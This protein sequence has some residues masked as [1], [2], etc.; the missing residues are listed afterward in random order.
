MAWH[1]R[2]MTGAA[3]AASHPT[4]GAGRPSAFV[5]LALEPVLPQWFSGEGTS[6][7]P[8]KRLMLAIL[9]DAIELLM[10]DPARQ[11]ARRALCQRKAAHWIYSNDR[12]WF[13]SFVNVCETL[14]YDPKRIRTGIA[15]SSSNA[16]RCGSGL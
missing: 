7:Q 11:H 15:P 6:L 5:S 13:F 8:A 3:V 14:G 1:S 2:R 9:T 4:T 16:I 10:Q 12:A